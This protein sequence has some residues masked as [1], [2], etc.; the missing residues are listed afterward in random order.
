MAAAASGGDPIRHVVLLILENHSFD[1]MLGG[2]KQIISGWDGADPSV[3]RVNKDPEG[4]EYRQAP[5]TERMMALDP[6]HEVQHVA[7]QLSDHNGGFVKDFAECY[8]QSDAK[9]RGYI[10]GYYPPDFL[11]ALHRLARNFTV[12]DRWFSCLPG[13]TWPNRFFAL[14]GTSSGRVNMPDDGTHKADIPGYFQQDQDTLFDR[15]NERGIH[16]K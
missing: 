8:P 9:A 4:R 6:H 14:T 1:Q 2:L 10:M 5:T 16:W 11:P 12:C 7:V 15:L 13:P 3:T